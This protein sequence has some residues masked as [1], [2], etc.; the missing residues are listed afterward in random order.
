MQPQ[1][2]FE[3]VIYEPHKCFWSVGEAEGNDFPFIKTN[4]GLKYCIPHII[5]VD[6][7]LIVTSC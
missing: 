1:M 4:F 6:S 2:W 3:D 7:N 5:W